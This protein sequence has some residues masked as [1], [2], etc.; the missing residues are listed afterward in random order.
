[1]TSVPSGSDVPDLPTAPLAFVDLAAQ[2]AEV[3]TQVLHDMDR[4]MRDCSFIGGAEVKSFEAAWASYCGQAHMVG[5]SSG[6]DALELALRA[7]GVGP[8]DEVVVPANSF[9]ASAGAV[10]RIGAHPVFIDCDPIHLLIDP[11]QLASVISDRT[12]AVMP[13][14]LYGQIAPMDELTSV[15]RRTG[16]PLVEDAAQAHG[17]SQ[18][19]RKAGSWGIAATYSFYPGKNLGAY[20]DAGAVGTDSEQIADAIEA[21]RNHGSRTRYEH[22]TVGFNC[23]LDTLQAV[24]LS[25]KLARLDEWNA[26]RRIAASRYDQMLASIAGVIR[27]S[28]RE[29]NED[30]WHLYVVRVPDRDRVLSALH[31]SGVP[32]AI[33]YPTPLHLTGAFAHLNHGQGEFPVAEKAAGEILSLPMHPH[34]SEAQQERV[35]EALAEALS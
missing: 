5:V 18:H 12:R 3:A 30:V 17:A 16:V 35:V 9:I 1:M 26:A 32:A 31:A 19:G 13:V 33:H 14:H 34:L 21:L 10:A 28:S 20:G 15:L 7:I 6:T 29:G 2:H 27:P 24:V 8:G 22:P 11:T 25:A 23:R 4:V